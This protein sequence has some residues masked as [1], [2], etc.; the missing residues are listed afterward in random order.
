MIMMMRELPSSSRTRH[1]FA[2]QISIFMSENEC[3]ICNYC[4]SKCCIGMCEEQSCR[5]DYLQTYKYDPHETEQ[6]HTE[7]SY[8]FLSSCQG[9]KGLK[10]FESEAGLEGTP[11]LSMFDGYVL[12][13]L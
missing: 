3:N 10:M 6:M 7:H 4:T 1:Y 8:V 12:V 13:I 2:T 11:C 5:C 9:K